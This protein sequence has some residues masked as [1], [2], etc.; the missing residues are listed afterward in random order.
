ME[1]T[2]HKNSLDCILFVDDDMATNYLN[3]RLIKKLGVVQKAVFCRNGREA[4]DYLE[5]SEAADYVRP[6]LIFLDINMPV[7]DGFEFLQAYEGLDED[8]RASEVVVMLTTSLM[9]NDQQR[10]ENLGVSEYLD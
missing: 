10:A 9:D 5:A 1:A 2:E 3:K 4:L 6:N 8:K 7:M